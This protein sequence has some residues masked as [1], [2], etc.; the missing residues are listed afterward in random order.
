MSSIELADRAQH[1]GMSSRTSVP[2]VVLQPEGEPAN[3]GPTLT[4]RQEWAYLGVLYWAYFVYGWNDGSTGPILL[5][6]QANY[7]I[8]YTI[9]SLLF[10]GTFIGYVFSAAL[11]VPLTDRFGFG[12]ICSLMSMCQAVAYALMASALPFPAMVTAFVLNGFSVGCLGAQANVLVTHLRNSENKLQLLHASYGI[13][14]TLSPLA[15]TFFS[16]ATHWSFL[17]LITA[18]FALVG[19]ALISIVFRLRRMEDLL[20]IHANPSAEEQAN[21]DSK[22]QQLLRFKA[23]HL[24]AFFLLFYEGLEVT[25]G[26]WIVTYITQVRGAGP[27]AGYISSGFWGGLTVGRLVLMWVNKKV[28]PRRA[29]FLYLV[30]AIAME[31]F[32]WFVPSV[33]GDAIAIAGVGLVLGPFF[34]LVVGTGSQLLPRWLL[35]GSIGWIA[36]VGQVGSALF[37]FLTGLLSQKFG[38]S[39]I[40]PL[41]VAM[42]ASCI[43]LW[44]LVPTTPRRTD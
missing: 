33:I 38:I 22:L 18:C 9:V 5:R 23:V 4:K 29:I 19:C 8:S 13:G 3:D 35:A 26:G 17:Y 34:P 40:Q 37:P 36:S 32:V 31:V 14:S 41:L 20:G 10:V 25:I 39:V 2:E 27:S 1:E 7:H 44:A 6:V 43:G 30:L 28:G 24:L 21:R 11:T 15:A 16:Q 12:K 42:M